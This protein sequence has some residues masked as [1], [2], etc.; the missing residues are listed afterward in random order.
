MRTAGTRA[1][2]RAQQ[3]GFIFSL[4]GHHLE[5]FESKTKKI[6]QILE[7]TVRVQH[8]IGYLYNYNYYLYRTYHTDEQKADIVV[9]CEQGQGSFT[10]S[11]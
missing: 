11:P 3:E 7:D 9:V 2:K 8:A 6:R 4:D 10:Q 1:H 5:R